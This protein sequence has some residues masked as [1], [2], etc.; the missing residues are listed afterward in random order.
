[1]TLK[2][3]FENKYYSSVM[4]FF[5]FCYT[6]FN[7]KYNHV[8]DIFL[9]LFL[10]GSLPIFT[11]Y[12]DKVYKN[13]IV[14]IFIMILILEVLSWT[15]SLIYMPEFADNTPKIDR[16]GKLF[17]FFIIAY[18]LNANIKNIILLW[19]FFILGFIV[20]IGVNMNINNI[21]ELAQNQQR[22]DFF[23]K[24]SQFDS[25]LSGT[26]FLMSLSLFYLTTKSSKF[27]K[28]TKNIIL[29]GLFLLIILFFYLVIIT[30]SRQVWLGL[31]STIFV[32][33]LSY[34][35]INKKFNFKILVIGFISIVA[36][37]FTI[38]NI[39]TVQ[40]RIMNEKDVYKSIFQENKAIEM[41]SIGIRVNSWLDAKDWIARHPIIGLDSEAISEV[42]QQSKRFNSDLKKQYGHLHNFFIE[43]LVAYG[44]VGLFL[45]FAMYYF[46]IKS[47]KSSD[48]P[49]EEKK[50][51]LL[52]AICFL[53]YWIVIN[54]F[55]T[56]NSRIIGVFTHNIIFASFFTFHI[57]SFL[58]TQSNNN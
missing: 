12:K 5:I 25:M 40:K 48:L 4:L 43:T 23:I 22:V 1:M 33:S 28:N 31:V 37:L 46:I 13:P 47:I 54:N 2:N 52:L 8:G 49:E 14:L 16:L 56:F 42:I 53:T 32:G 17:V 44:F 35:L 55:E 6:F 3:I 11:I 21:I 15:N 38:S 34:I 58:K 24:N 19:F 57:T 18:W 39:N 26:S 27:N 36:I 45:I 29:F 20:A 50:Y 51:Y 10:I 9:G 7:I 41:S 30:Q